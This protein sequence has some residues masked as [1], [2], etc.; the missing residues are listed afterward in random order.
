MEGEIVKKVKSFVEKECKKPTSKYGEEP[1]TFH[2]SEVAKYAL[3]LAEKH[4]EADKE[5][6]EIAAWLHDIGSIIHGRENHHLIGAEIAEKKLLELN[7]PLE[8]INLIKK[9]IS[10]HRESIESKRESI[11]EQLLA[12]ADALSNFDNLSGIFKAAFIFENK[13]QGEA[14]ISVRAK[15]EGCYNKLS[16][17]AQKIIKPKYDAVNLL[18]K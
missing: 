15:L 13:T 7:Y 12:E 14:K 11:E 6:I 5:V 18:L 10:H 3:Q 2:F 16:S 1:F 8:K 17:D 9:C 4:P